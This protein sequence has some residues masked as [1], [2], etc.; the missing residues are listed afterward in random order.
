MFIDF[1]AGTEGIDWIKVKL[2]FEGMIKTWGDW[3]LQGD[4]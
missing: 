1:G 4:I 2:A 3:H